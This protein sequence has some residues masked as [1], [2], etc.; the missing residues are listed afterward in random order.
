MVLVVAMSLGHVVEARAGNPPTTAKQKKSLLLTK[1]VITSENPKKTYKELSKKDRK[2][3]NKEV[4][5]GKSRGVIRKVR[6]FNVPA[7]Q[8]NDPTRLPAAGSGQWNCIEVEAYVVHN[9]GYSGWVLSKVS[10]VSEFC[11]FQGRIQ[12]VVITDTWTEVNYLG[13]RAGGTQKKTKNT[14]NSGRSVVRQEWIYGAGGWDLFRFT[15]CVQIG[16]NT[17]LE[18]TLSLKC[19]LS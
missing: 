14:G 4:K 1:K 11:R 16:V 2:I 15:D 19:S 8:R 18:A 6:R 9:G 3:L 10:Q 5:K 12:S 7:P 17:R 13:F